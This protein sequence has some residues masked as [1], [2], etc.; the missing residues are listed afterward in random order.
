MALGTAIFMV[1][2]SLVSASEGGPLFGPGD[3][4]FFLPVFALL[5]IEL[6][7][8]VGL[9]LRKRWA[10]YAAAVGI[11]GFAMILVLTIGV[12]VPW[13]MLIAGAAIASA[14]AWLLRRLAPREYFQRSQID[15]VT[16]VTD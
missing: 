5:L 10:I 8:V 11:G 14:C 13:F 7:A 16:G 4:W 1:L 2:M 6:A 3:I 9:L 15:S 12:I